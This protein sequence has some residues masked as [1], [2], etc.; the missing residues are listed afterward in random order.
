MRMCFCFVLLSLALF[1]LSRV[2]SCLLLRVLTYLA[3]IVTIFTFLPNTR[4][5]ASDFFL[6]QDFG[7]RSV[8]QSK[9]LLFLAYFLISTE[10]LLV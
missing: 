6:I 10:A 9:L 2:I 3:I 8:S 1:D 4:M 5:C 7:L